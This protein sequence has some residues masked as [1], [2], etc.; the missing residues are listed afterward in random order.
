MVYLIDLWGEVAHT[1]CMP[2]PALHGC[3][4]HRGTVVYN[5][6][7]DGPGNTFVTANASKGGVLLEVDSAGEV[8]WEV[9]QPDHHHNGLRLANGNALLLRLG[10]PTPS[11]SPTTQ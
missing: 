11:G 5:G 3:L 7:I 1:W 8:L 9:R 10:G 4:T 6:R 2:H